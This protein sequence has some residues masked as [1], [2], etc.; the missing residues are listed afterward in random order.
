MKVL[1]AEDDITTL[2]TL[3]ALLTRWGHKVVSVQDGN[4]AWE[5]LQ[6]PNAPRLAILDWMMPGLDGLK[7]CLRIRQQEMQVPAYIILL[8]SR[9]PE[10][11]IVAGLEAG[12]NDYVT[13]PFSRSELRVRILAGQRIVELQSTLANR[14]KELQDALDHVKILQGILPICMHCHKIRDDQDVWQ[15]L[16]KYVSERSLA[17]FSH[18]LCPE[19]LEK[20]YPEYSEPKQND[21]PDQNKQ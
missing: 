17:E 13:K 14:V 20:Y 10:E 1:I 4:K 16:E 19:C 5:V 9:D 15:R 2:K 12:A 18:G 6:S 3:E 8:T 7:L 11:D 21:V